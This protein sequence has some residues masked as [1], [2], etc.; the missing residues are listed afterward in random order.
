MKQ[1]IRNK[2]KRVTSM[3]LA[4]QMIIT[5]PAA[6]Q[7]LPV[8]SGSELV[9]TGHYAATINPTMGGGSLSLSKNS[10]TTSPW[11]T[12]NEALIPG[13]TMFW[14][15]ENRF[16]GAKIT[17]EMSMKSLSKTYG[18]QG[19]KLGNEVHG[20]KSWFLFSG[21]ILCAGAGIQ[22][23]TENRGQII[24][25]VDNIPVTNDTKLALTNPS[26]GYR[27]VL[28]ASANPVVWG[29]LINTPT[30]GVHTQRNWLSASSLT[31][32]KALEW[33]YV[34]GDGETG[35]HLSA[36]NVYYRLNTK[37][38]DKAQLAEFFIAPGETYQYTMVA[39]KTTDDY[40]NSSLYRTN[41]RLLINTPQIQAASS[42]GEGIVSVNKWSSG[43]IRLDNQVVP[44]TMNEC[45]AL[46]VKK[47]PSTG[48]IT[49][50]IAK[51]DSQNNGYLEVTLESRGKGILTNSNPM[52]LSE[53]TFDSK[54]FLKFD[55]SKMGTEPVVLT[56]EGKAAEAITGDEIVL[57]RGEEGRIEKPVE[58]SGSIN[59]EVKIPK[60]DGNYVRNAGSS[61]IKRELLEGEIDGTRKAG[62]ADGSHI[63]SV[64][65]LSGEG[66][67]LTA[68][69]KGIVT[70][71]ATDETGKQ[72]KW[73]VTVL[74]EDPAN[75]PQAGPEDYEIIRK[76]WKDSLIGNDLTE[77]N[78]GGDILGD[79]EDQAK[80]AWEAYA[81]KGQ[82]S[83]AGIPWPQDEGA[84]GNPDV[85][86]ENDAVEFRP[87]FKKMMA[88]AKAY[89]AKGN[90]YY[91]NDEL[92]K[93]MKQILNYLCSRCYSPKTQTDN[94]WTWE[95]GV[96][97]DLLPI[98][99]LLYDHLTEEEISLYT[100]GLYF[101][102]PDPYHEGIIGTGSTHAQGYRTAQG[103]NIIDCSRIAL[104][105]GILREDNE[106][107][108]LAQKAS[109]ETFI[110]Q[111]LKDSTKIA[112]Q[113]YTSGF[114]EDGS[115]LDHSHVPYLGSYG[116]E[117]IKGGAG[118]PPLFA[119]TPWEYP[120][121]VQE[122]LEF[123][124]K[125]GFLNGMYDGLMLDSLK[126]RSVSR[127]AGSNRD[128]GRE[129]MVL[130]IQLM[131]SVSLEVQEELKSSLKTWLEIDPGFI[132]T[133]TG[134]E[135]IMI[136]AKALEILED[137]SITSSIAPIHKNLPLMDRAIHRTDKF[138]M[139]LSMYSE[140]IQNTEIMNHENRYGWHQ[141]SGMTYLY[142][143]DT[144]QYTENFW[145]TVNPLRLA[146]TTL[147]SKNIGNGQPDS[148]G[149]AQ[150]G[151]FRSR[152][153]WVGG[154]SIENDGI[155]GM[156]L[157]GEVRVKEGEGSPAVTYSP[158]LSAK[159]S[160]F[161]FG[162]QIICLGAGI[163]N[164]DE[165]YP[166][167]SIIENRRLRQEGDNALIINGKTKDLMT[168]PASLE[169][170]VEGKVDVSGTTLSDISWAHLEGN[171]AG[172]DIGYYFPA[173]SQTISVRKARNAG[174]WSL[175]GTS[176][177]E[178]EENYLEM[179]FDHGKNPENAAYEYVLLPGLT[180][181]ETEQ[182]SR[183]PQITV[184]SNTSQIQ[185]VYSRFKN[186]LGANI[187]T[188]A[189][190]K[191]G[192][193][194]VKGAASLM[195]KEDENGILT[196]SASD[197]TMKNTGTIV[198]EI[199][200]PV[201]EILSS[202][203][204]VRAELTEYGAKLTIQTKG[205][206]GSSSYATMQMAA[207]LYPQAVTLAPGQ[208]MSFAVND[209]TNDAGNISWKVTGDKS[210]ESGTGID[211]EGCLEIDDYEEN[212]RLKV[213][214]ELENG[215]TLQAFVS[216]G[217]KAETELPK[218]VQKVQ[219]LIESAVTEA[220]NNDDY[221]NY[222]VQKAIRSAVNALTAVSNEE[223][224]KYMM[225]QLITLEE[226]YKAAM[227]ANDCIIDSMV[228]TTETEIT[229][230]E[231]AGAA[232]S[233]PIKITGSTAS[234][235][236]AVRATASDAA[237]AS[238]SAAFRIFADE[239]EDQEIRMAVM[240]VKDGS[241]SE[242]EE[243]FSK[244]LD[245]QLQL[246][247][248]YGTRRPI[249]LNAPVKVWMD[250]PDQAKGWNSIIGTFKGL[251]GKSRQI[252]VYP[253]RKGDKISFVM[254][255]NGTVT[256]K[257]DS[258]AGEEE[259]FQVSIDDSLEGGSITANLSE[260][261]KGR[262]VIVR[263]VPD[264]GYDLRHLSVN[265]K[266]VSP[267]KTGKYEFLLQQDTY[268]T[269]EF[270]KIIL[271]EEESSTSVTKV[272]GWKKADGKWYYFNDKGN[273]ITG[274]LLDNGKW[275]RLGTDGAMQ[276]GW[277]FD[278]MDGCWYYLD[279]SGTMAQ[280]WICIDEKW[281]YLT[282]QAEGPSGWSLNHGKWEYKKPEGHSRPNGSLYMNDVT[283]DGRLV[284]SNG[285]WI[286]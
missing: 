15:G 158:H 182:Y 48:N 98:L 247:D 220:L 87:A 130:M 67:L 80:S 178:A 230:I 53:S 81:Y 57:V 26:N 118:M 253:D 54:I 149:F 169:D 216:L 42:V 75:L 68:N 227:A 146:G 5:V 14:E 228:D 36:S 191:I 23:Q 276:T 264:I 88:M 102:Q 204:N 167:E 140:R 201:T 279:S 117:F 86:Y 147:V 285:V 116:I 100:E 122:N 152:E 113:G 8:I 203:E 189:A 84:A 129:A 200:K 49:L 208:S 101:F 32:K 261:K 224:A 143:Q 112:D 22:T 260:G 132:E 109:S 232:L 235:S 104:G 206:N 187:W 65:K 43:S 44:L 245:L 273:K 107:V 99:V 110:I 3:C 156:S 62:D 270:R 222:K 256:L 219:S 274:W 226:L 91:Q 170:I 159:K 52:A 190:A 214:A 244:S 28:T 2:W 131:D 95:I 183:E 221:S 259:H 120:R 262:K 10:D 196:V 215:T 90:L 225:D 199:N 119:G 77:L 212:S 249:S 141:G 148:S 240:S 188:D 128:A 61:K 40:S 27:N 229:G 105:L 125:E 7:T 6:G 258:T 173:G 207:S 106:L 157:T 286:Q 283:P 266:N 180:S 64:R 24:T 172:S 231:I 184:L 89:A 38:S 134:A 150:G 254:T 93:D 56:I 211:G 161:M 185:A 16:Q 31:D 21:E 139:A 268:I 138:L 271:D 243:E 257:A 255:E 19:V 35:S 142:N 218:N 194:S 205:T 92:L 82:N 252:P 145:N 1:K 83:C 275:F 251:D 181:E 272:S 177:G 277:I 278:Q 55:A 193:L 153:S 210:L 137:D 74:Y 217:G 154:S 234:P 33:S 58:L 85:P 97:K 34:F 20:V 175:V 233:I 50:S 121:E 114:Y 13:T 151:D 165:E 29:P 76:R 238:P 9:N 17:T 209:Y 195:A 213:T 282:P 284:D 71:L 25:V 115:Y 263:A 66:A 59:W 126:G 135:Y 160:W 47:D 96:P 46:T 69:E 162:E 164:S 179:W 51:P 11:N 236:N 248:K 163:S 281:Y 174:D 73:N 242:T 60:A 186:I 72:K 94:W 265:G 124:L 192:D 269:G 241:V 70:V 45:M 111:S 39:G 63:A 108:H 198:I 171:T 79:I 166:V 239:D 78:G 202:D 197:P 12:M 103:A 30:K 176:K 155:N 4:M 267:D 223:L 133:L 136:K 37:E 123:Y 168:E 127:P 144:M 237:K 246:E 250:I 41:A 18:V 280:G